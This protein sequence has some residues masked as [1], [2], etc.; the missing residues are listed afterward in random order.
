MVSIF[1][2]LAAVMHQIALIFCCAR[3][4]EWNQREEIVAWMPQERSVLW[5]GVWRACLTRSV[6]G[7]ENA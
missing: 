1:D 3:G 7:L 6:L 5:S 2:G 4:I